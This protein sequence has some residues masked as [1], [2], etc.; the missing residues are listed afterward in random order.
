[1]PPRL[2]DSQRQAVLK[3]LAQGFDRETIA[4]RVGVSL[5][6]ISTVAAHVKMGT[7]EKHGVPDRVVDF[8]PPERPA[9]VHEWLEEIR[10]VSRRAQA[11]SSLKRILISIDTETD[12]EVFWNPDPSNG[13]ANPH[14]LILGESGFGI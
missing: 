5:G 13:T 14:M 3:L 6:Q 1:M 7:Y 10:T 11:E 8:T 12:E 4:A 2:T 9:R